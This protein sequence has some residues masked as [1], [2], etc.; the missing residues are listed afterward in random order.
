MGP[1]Q[2][3]GLAA[4]SVAIAPLP[5]V[6]LVMERERRPDFARQFRLAATTWAM[7]EGRWSRVQS[8]LARLHKPA[9]LLFDSDTQCHRNR[10]QC[11]SN[12]DLSV[13]LNTLIF[14]K[15]KRQRVLR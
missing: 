4:N 13:R 7:V 3:S 1:R 9:I 5:Q 8:E 10:S 12:H 14:L 11:T 6:G 15:E 2:G